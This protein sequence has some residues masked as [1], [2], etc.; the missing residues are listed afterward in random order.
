MRI[1]STIRR[2]AQVNGNG[3]A[4]DYLDRQQTWS[5]FASRIARLAGGLRGIGLAPGDRIAMLALNSDRYLEY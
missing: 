1:S 3:L 4:T 5:E 2:A